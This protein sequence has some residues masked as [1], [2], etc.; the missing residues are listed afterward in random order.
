MN[1]CQYS[2]AVKF[3]QSKNLQNIYDRQNEL[4]EFCIK[5]PSLDFIFNY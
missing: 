2:D 4:C 3:P 5:L 1:D